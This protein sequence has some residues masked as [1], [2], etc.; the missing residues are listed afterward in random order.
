MRVFVIATA[1]AIVAAWALLRRLPNVTANAEAAVNRPIARLQE[2]RSVALDGK[3]LPDARLREVLATRP[4]DL[5]DATHLEHDREA[6]EQRLAELG[7]L[8]A[9]VEPAVV[10]YDRAGAAYVTFEIAQ[11]KRFHLRNVEVTGAGS[12]AVV[13]T[14]TPGDL[15]VR[16]RI[17]SA[18]DALSD[19]LERRL[20]HADVVRRPRGE[21]ALPTSVELSVHTDLAE[22]AVDVTFATR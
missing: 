6:M 17:E 8:A 14:L 7:Y 4:G 1:L 9:R 20:L 2:V 13:V 11:G 3:Q 15:A 21:P 12:G 18:R 16:D 5:L 19:A 22:G 10:T